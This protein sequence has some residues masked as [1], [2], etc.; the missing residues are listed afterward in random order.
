M[1]GIAGIIGSQKY[2]ENDAK[3][4]IDMISY[5]GPDE[6]GTVNLGN[7]Y[8]G[9]ARLAVVDPENGTQPMSNEDDSV[10]VVFNGEIYNHLEIRTDLQKKGYTFKSRCDTEVLVHLWREKGINMLDDLIG[11]FAFCLWD[12]KKEE[13]ILV[14]DRQG[15]K[16][17]Y[18]T[19]LIDGGFAFA[20]EIKSLLTLD[21]VD[22]QID[23]VG[24]NLLHSFNYC[25]PP[26]TCYKDISHLMPGTYIEFDKNGF[27]K[28][29]KY[30]HWPLSTDKQD[31]N[32]NDLNN[33]L[34]D[35]IKLQ[36][37]FDV[38]GCLFLSGG[39]DSSLIA[40]HLS[41]NWNKEKIISFS[42]NSKQEG[43]GEYHLAK[44]VAR[45]INKI[46]L[47]PV[48][49]DFSIVPENIEKV[50]FHCDQPH[51][52][53]S[54]FLIRELC[55]AANK[56]G[57]IVAFNGDGPDE[58]LAGFTHNQDFL[59]SQT[60][61]NFPLL[62]YFNRI[63]FMPERNREL[64]LN[65]SFRNVVKN[66][67]DYFDA[68]LSDWRDLDPID[69]IAAYECTSLGPGN[70]LIKTDRMGAALSIEGRSP[71]LDHRI[72]EI[73]ARIPQ[74]QKLQN[75]VSKF[76]LKEYGLRYFD[77]DL[78]FRQKSMP[79]LPIGEWIK[80]PLYE[81]ALNSIK[82][83]DQSRYNVKN[84]IKFLNK[85]RDGEFNYTKELR[86][87]LMSSHWINKLKN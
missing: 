62:E 37:R 61:T 81:W 2:S 69:Q 27:R 74:S 63:C 47:L 32:L 33:I 17:C 57:I 51:G 45:E 49:Y 84:A 25:L 44:S 1:C 59:A 50:L 15:I 70:N 78:M 22:I 19:K 4:M 68:I 80:G 29:K 76:L 18:I 82:Q 11:M 5:R 41:N 55:K 10:W 66:P 14:R 67:I 54:F 87:L 8:L 60:R 52:D 38:N 24:L 43:Y 28:E 35:A 36:M 83:L 16:P 30:W 46:D 3:K 21:G 20:S 75:S 42:L 86:T 73:F 12:K 40:A 58:I 13:G 72:S 85:H 77:R 7:I 26:R 48:D 6:Q 71:F 79:T 65:D 56:K 23:D 39:V 53:F 31:L 34:D 9:H 64:L